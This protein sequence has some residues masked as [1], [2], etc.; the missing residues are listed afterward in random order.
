MAISNRP[1]SSSATT[2]WVMTLALNLSPFMRFDGY[3]IS[4]DALDMPNLH[5]RSFAVARAALRNT[6]LFG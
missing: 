2:A 3:F 6:L 1:C 4:P 5:E